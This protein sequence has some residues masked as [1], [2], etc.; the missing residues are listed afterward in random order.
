[1][2][3]ALTWLLVFAATVACG[4]ASSKTASPDAVA[5]A[6]PD[7]A[8]SDGSALGDTSEVPDAVGP[9]T[10]APDVAG[11]DTVAPDTVAPDTVA[12]DTVAPDT[13]A[14]D[15]AQPSDATDDVEPGI[16]RIL[17]VGNSFTFFNDLEQLWLSLRQAQGVDD[18]V[19]S[20]RATAAGYRWVQHLADATADGGA[21]PIREWLVT[22]PPPWDFVVLQE[23]SQIPGFP[24]GNPE[25]DASVDAAVAL[26][27]YAE[28]A[29]ATPVLFETWGYRTG[30]PQNAD[31]FTDYPVMQDRLDAGFDEIAA[32]IA[33]AGKAPVRLR[34]GAAFRVVYDAALA[35]K[36]DPLAPGALF[37]RLYTD[38]GR[39]PSALGSY[40]TAC[41]LAATLSPNGTVGVDEAPPGVADVDAALLRDAAETAVSQSMPKS[42]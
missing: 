20:L 14:L 35:A 11:P 19:V 2:R 4:E 8:A 7:T 24:A 30:D 15:T 42:R 39:H 17:W 21:A 37:S 10:A 18:S 33:A 29:G 38:D 25:H 16:H 26:A 1:M 31:L 27:G 13:A 5:Q 41:V 12:P 28:A 32:A 36:E 34:A 40:L 23:Q 3:R 9:D 6:A 22:A